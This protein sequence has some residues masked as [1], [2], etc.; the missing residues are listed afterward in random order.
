MQIPTRSVNNVTSESCYVCFIMVIQVFIKAEENLF[1]CSKVICLLF[2]LTNISIYLY[3]IYFNFLLTSVFE[4]ENINKRDQCKVGDKWWFKGFS[5]GTQ[6][7]ILDTILNIRMNASY[8]W[9]LCSQ[10]SEKFC[11]EIIWVWCYRIFSNLR[12]I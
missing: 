10:D 12:N 6:K 11:Y 7:G 8:K 1:Y 9:Y 4:K 5:S 3:K 2:F